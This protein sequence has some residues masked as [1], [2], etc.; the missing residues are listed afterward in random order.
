MN[1]SN[2]KD[3]I[4]K[5]EKDNLIKSQSNYEEAWGTDAYKLKSDEEII[6]FISNF[7]YGETEFH[8]A[9]VERLRWEKDFWKNK[10]L[11]ILEEIKNF[12]QKM[13]SHIE[14]YFNLDEYNK[15]II[16]GKFMK[17]VDIKLLKKFEEVLAE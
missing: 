1:N 9:D 15:L 13:P 4:E 2:Y 16:F 14:E 7:G 12:N 11:T 3:I 10:C 5:I 17:I 6:E 8:T